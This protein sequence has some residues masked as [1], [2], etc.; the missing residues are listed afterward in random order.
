MFALLLVL[1]TLRTLCCG[2]V[3]RTPLTGETMGTGWTLT[4]AKPGLTRA[5]RAQLQVTV[6]QTLDAVDAAM[7]T[8]H[9]DSELARLNAHAG[10]ASFALSAPVFRVL[11]A[12]QQISE[13]S[14]GAFDVTLGPL[15]AAW[16][17]GAAARAAD[18]APVPAELAALRARVGYRQLR[19]DLGLRSVRKQSG[20]LE[21]DLSA[22][23]KGF[24]VDRVAEE[25]LA[26]GQR[27]FL[28]EVGGEVRAA[29]ERPGGGPWRV[30]IERPLASERAPHAVV[31]LRDQALATSGD[32]RSFHQ[33]AGQRRSHLIDPRTGRPLT[34]RLASVS[35]VHNQAMLADA[36]ATAL[37]VLGP[38]Q[39]RHVAIARGLGAYG[40]VRLEDGG[41]QSF[42]TPGFPPTREIAAPDAAPEAR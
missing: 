19:L 8:W 30:A 7:S 27:D 42:T 32:Y 1:L 34:H 35:V 6:Q 24:G 36:W 38:E 10:S 29:G 23:A 18:A 41:E 28:I 22:I 21:L 17:F 40:I 20:A 16:G 13:Q 37:M 12:A 4:L 14:A 2:D 33:R 39:G 25:L 15:V 26:R 5:E 9:A 11:Q 31:E 3:A